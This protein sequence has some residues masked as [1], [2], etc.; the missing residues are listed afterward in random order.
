MPKL[1]R[2]ELVNVL[3][4]RNFAA[5]RAAI[6]ADAKAARSAAAVLTAA[7]LGWIEALEL[8]IHSGADVNASYRNY[9]PLHALIQERPHKPG[10]TTSERLACLKWLL[11]H[12]ADPELP[13]A[14]P[15]M[16]AILV[17]AFA[18]EPRYVNELKK[19]GARVDGFV[20]AALGDLRRVE[21]SLKSD[22]GFVTAR[23]PGGLTALHCAAGSR[24]GSKSPKTRQA[25]FAISKLLLDKGADPAAR[26][27][28]WGQDVDALYF[29][30]SSEQ[31]DVLELML[32]RGAD[33][34]SA[35]VHA[36]WK[37]LGIAEICLKHGAVIDRARDGEKPLLNQMIR[38]GQFEPAQWL[39]DHGASPNLR[40][41][42]GWTAV[43]QAAS[44]GNEQM[45][46]AVLA[47]G[48]DA[49][50]KGNAGETPAEIAR[51]R[52]RGKLAA[53][54]AGW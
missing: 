41:E 25:L 33:A 23:D 50:R 19:G 21:R 13:G 49:S 14:W 53:M 31:T 15:S 18:G 35:L 39:L 2:K 47:A 16:R 52:R 51:A 22:P 26:L 9:R 1:E 8:L 29:A 30:T 37:D 10:Q 3:R 28:S 46:K 7:Q 27:R 54:L 43:H 5:V 40:D 48:G 6:R 42:Q 34:T 11:A 44:R 45:L 20:A 38:W 36:V 32:E 12:G 4:T 17:A 24:L